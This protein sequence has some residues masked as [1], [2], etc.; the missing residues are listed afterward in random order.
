M[1]EAGDWSDDSDAGTPLPPKL[2]SVAQQILDNMME[3]GG[4]FE[5]AQSIFGKQLSGKAKGKKATSRAQRASSATPTP[6]LSLVHETTPLSYALMVIDR[7][8]TESPVTA[9]PLPAPMLS[10]TPMRHRLS[11]GQERLLT[12]MKTAIALFPQDTKDPLFPHFAEEVLIFVHHVLQTPALKNT[13]FQGMA[14]N[15]SFKFQLSQVI[16]A[17]GP[18]P[19]TPAPTSIP[20]PPAPLAARPR[21]ADVETAVTPQKP[22]QARVNPAPSP[23]PAAPPKHAPAKAVEAPRVPGKPK[24]AGVALKPT[25]PLPLPPAPLSSRARRRRR[26]K[27]TS[28]GLSRCGVVEV[29]FVCLQGN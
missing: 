14:G 9:S 19:P 6:S 29:V 5:I 8:P 17:A 2:A 15:S 13:T 26:G 23:T 16:A 18:P 4:D 24:A 11:L 10:P 12:S 27:H 7:P 22:K 25:A 1:S 20:P 3:M 28:H 21:P